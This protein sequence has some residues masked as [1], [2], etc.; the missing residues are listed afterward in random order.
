MPITPRTAL[1]VYVSSSNRW[2]RESKSLVNRD[3]PLTIVSIRNFQP[4]TEWVE[5]GDKFYWESRNFE[6]QI[7]LVRKNIVILSIRLNSRMTSPIKN[8]HFPRFISPELRQKKKLPPGF[9]IIFGSSFKWDHFRSILWKL[10][11]HPLKKSKKQRHFYVIVLHWSNNQWALTS[12]SCIA[13][14]KISKHKK[15]KKL[16]RNFRKKWRRIT[17]HLMLRETNFLKS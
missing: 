6:I 1:L 10:N 16:F 3:F 4:I 5:R 17:A 2:K 7:A 13:L 15:N 12:C 9:P 8:L 14:T 11:R